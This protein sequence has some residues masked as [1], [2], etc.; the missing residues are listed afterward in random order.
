MAA[1]LRETLVAEFEAGRI[2]YAQGCRILPVD[3]RKVFFMESEPTPDPNRALV[4][5]NES[6]IAAAAALAAESDVAIVAV[7]DMSGLFGSGTV[8]E[9]CDTDSLVLPGV[10]ATLVDAVLATGTPTVVVLFAGRPYDL[11]EIEQR[12]AAI[13][14]AGFPGA[15][16]AGAVA[17]ILSGK[18]NPSGKLTVTF[19]RSAGVQPMF[20]NNK[21]LSGGLPRAEYYKAVFPF[22]HGLGYA[23]FDYEDIAVSR[24][25]W[26]IGARIEVACTVRN[27]GDVAG[28][29]I[30]Q[31]YV[32][33]PVGSI[34]RPVI[35][36]KGFH[37]VRLAPGESRRV[38]FDL[39]SDMLSFTGEDMRPVVEPG[40]IIVKIGASSADIR[41][42]RKMT[43]VGPVTETA[44]EREFFTRSDDRPLG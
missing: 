32:T 19:P 23:R 11:S 4:D 2:D 21:I 10:Q 31:L 35:E 9:G 17:R 34:V 29:E 43:V 24:R 20:Y 26:P 44:A 13:L 37:R 40:E 22:G 38:T 25:D 12:A 36:L 39:H 5:M 16:G 41:L 33:D 8:G 28:E 42:E 18:V 3:D 30:V 15:E 6:G 1:T 27:A 7:G 14:F